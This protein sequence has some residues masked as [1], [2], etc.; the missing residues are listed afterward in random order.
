MCNFVQ[1][2]HCVGSWDADV[3]KFAEAC[4]YAGGEDTFACCTTI[5]G[6]YS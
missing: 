3:F 2:D 1:R 5:L 6:V 4:G